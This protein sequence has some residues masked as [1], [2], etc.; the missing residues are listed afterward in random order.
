MLY[1][2]NYTRGKQYSITVCYDTITN[3]DVKL[4]NLTIKGGYRILHDIVLKTMLCYLLCNNLV[5]DIM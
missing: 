1:I 3:H 2:T 5:F 4:I